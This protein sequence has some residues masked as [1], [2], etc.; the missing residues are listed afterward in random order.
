MSTS[1]NFTKIFIIIK[2]GNTYFKTIDDILYSYD[3][4]RLIS[5]PRGKAFANRTYEIPEGVTFMNEMAFSRNKNIDT[6]II[7]SSYVIERYIDANNNSYGFNN[8][9][10]SLSLAIYR[11]TSIK[12]YEVKNDNPR[13]SSYEGCI[14]S[15][16]GTELIA[17]PLHYTG[18]LNIKAGT[19]SIGQE[20]FWTFLEA[21]SNADNIT[22]INIP[23]SV[24]TIEA[25]QLATLNKLMNR[26]T[27][28]VTITIDSSNTAYEIS[29]NQ[30]VAR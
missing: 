28:P 17:V 24:T 19:T 6:V 14:Y 8:T 22:S 11:Y 12:E 21:I 16:D 1:T 25:N 15:K 10:N 26:S 2:Y 9:G 18:V 27:N 3:G 4:T 30:I 29:N 13:Y 20:A 7:P 5:V 23:A